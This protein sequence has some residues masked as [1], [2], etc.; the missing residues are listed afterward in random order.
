MHN[1]EIN[2]ESKMQNSQQGV[3]LESTKSISFA[4]SIYIK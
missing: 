3:I 1:V 2:G 4:Y